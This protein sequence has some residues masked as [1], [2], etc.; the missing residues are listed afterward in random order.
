MQVECSLLLT[1]NIPTLSHPYSLL[2]IILCETRATI[3]VNGVFVT[4]PI[5]KVTLR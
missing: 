4:L 5:E 1:N 2:N 3:C